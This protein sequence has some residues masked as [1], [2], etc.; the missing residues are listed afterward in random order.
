MVLNDHD[1]D[2]LNVVQHRSGEIA[3][4]DQ[5][6][7]QGRADGSHFFEDDDYT[8]DEQL[9]FPSSESGL[10][11]YSTSI[12]DELPR[13]I[14]ECLDEWRLGTSIPFCDTK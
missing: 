11:H 13:E 8:Q 14:E 7:V 6:C 10:D 5:V 4:Q 2:G 12:D 3:F 1:C 9:T